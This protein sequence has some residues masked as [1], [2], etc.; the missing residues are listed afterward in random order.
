MGP[1]APARRRRHPSP[2]CQL[3]PFLWLASAHCTFPLRLGSVGL[4]GQVGTGDSC[5]AGS[6][7]EFFL[8]SSFPSGPTSSVGKI[9][10]REAERRDLHQKKNMVLLTSTQPSITFTTFTTFATFTA[11]YYFYYSHHFH[12]FSPPLHHLQCL[13]ASRLKSCTTAFDTASSHWLIIFATRT[14]SHVTPPES[15]Q[16]KKNQT[17]S[18]K[19]KEAKS[20]KD[21]AQKT[22]VS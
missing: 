8:C 10:V 3:G 1:L 13:D 12:H 7:V 20:A 19:A 5:L 14:I 9:R 2:H 18:S 21:E 4:G 16:L 15:E 6:V 22:A 11:F 17:D